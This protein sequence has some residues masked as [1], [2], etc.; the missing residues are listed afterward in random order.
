MKRGFLITIILLAI[1][2]GDSLAQ[3]KKPVLVGIQ[4]S[5]TVEPF[6]EKGEFDVNVLPLIFETPIGSRMSIRL[7]PMANYHIGGTSNGI[8]DI[9]FFTVLPVFFEKS[10][11]KESRLYGFYIGPVLGFGRNL[12]N[13]HY[14]STIA[15]EPGYMFKAKKSFIITLGIQ[16]GASYFSYDSQPNEWVFHWG[17][18]ITFGFWID[19]TN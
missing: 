4:P 12:L 15:I 10:E 6:Y 13:D 9:A 5:I 2:I 18:K 19:R 17:P 16:L 14:T 8:S 3:S 1:S 7:S 11:S